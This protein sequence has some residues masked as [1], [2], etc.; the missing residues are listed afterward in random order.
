M[1]DILCR[2]YGQSLVKMIQKFEK[3]EYC[4][5]KAELDLEFLLCCRDNNA[6][7]YLFFFYFHVSSQSLKISL[8]HKQ[9]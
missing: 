5:R 4:L 2:R 9:C 6:M 8:T 7:P 1:S 3:I